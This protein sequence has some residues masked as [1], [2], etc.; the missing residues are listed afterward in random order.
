MCVVG[1]ECE[2]EISAGLLPLYLFSFIIV[3][4]D[5]YV[6][7]YRLCAVIETLCEVSC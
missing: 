7:W 3:P 6:I 2:E 1:I 4:V 5:L